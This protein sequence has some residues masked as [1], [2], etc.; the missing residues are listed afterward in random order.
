MHVDVLWEYINTVKSFI[1][2]GPNF[3]GFMKMGKFAVYAIILMTHQSFSVIL[4]SHIGNSS[5]F[6]SVMT[7]GPM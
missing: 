1:F 3:C 2:V 6:A 5:Q 4:L 7:D